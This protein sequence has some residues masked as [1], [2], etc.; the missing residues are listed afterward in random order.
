MAQTRKLAAEYRRMTGQPLAVSGE[1]AKYDAAR[2]LDLEAQ[3]DSGLGYDA[4][5]RG[6]VRAGKRVQI[7]GRAIFDESKGGQRLG[8]LKLDQDWDS[9]VLVL[10]DEDFETSEIWEADREEILAAV[11]EGGES[12]RSKRGLM[13]VAKFKAIGHLAWTREEGEVS[14]EVWKNF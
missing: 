10:M 9:V 4:V 2:L 1:I 5:G 14:D 7:K 13:S 12:K 8:Q 3:K 6:G 11:E